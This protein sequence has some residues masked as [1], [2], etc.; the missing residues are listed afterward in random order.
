MANRFGDNR[1]FIQKAL[2]QHFSSRGGG[3]LLDRFGGRQQLSPRSV[4]CGSQLFPDNVEAAIHDIEKHISRVFP[5]HLDSESFDMRQHLFSYVRLAHRGGYSVLPRVLVSAAVLLLFS[6]FS[7]TQPLFFFSDA[8][9][10]DGFPRF[11]ETS[12]GKLEMAVARSL[13]EDSMSALIVRLDK[14]SAYIADLEQLERAGLGAGLFTLKDPVLAL[15]DNPVLYISPGSG[16]VLPASCLG[17]DPQPGDTLVLPVTPERLLVIYWKKPALSAL[18]R[19]SAWPEWITRN[20]FMQIY[21]PARLE[22]LYQPLQSDIAQ[23]FSTIY[24]ELRQTS[25]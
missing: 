9:P 18:E 24:A 17:N 1:H 12:D 2:I 6:T 20:A 8:R 25:D 23:Y 14:L 22:S 5:I 13:W 11:R 4:Y 7:R 3:I 10:E 15:S 21:L 16:K 19:Q